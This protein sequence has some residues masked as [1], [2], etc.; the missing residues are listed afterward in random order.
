MRATVALKRQPLHPA[1]LNRLDINRPRPQTRKRPRPSLEGPPRNRDRSLDNSDPARA[2][3]HTQ[4][5]ACPAHCALW[6]SPAPAGASSWRALCLGTPTAHSPLP[7]FALSPLATAPYGSPGSMP[8]GWPAPSPQPMPRSPEPSSA[9][10]VRTDGWIPP[11]PPWP[12]IPGWIRAP[13]AAPSAVWPMPACSPGSAGWSG[14]AGPRARPP[15]PIA[16]CRRASHCRRRLLNIGGAVPGPSCPSQARRP[17]KAGT[18]SL[19]RWRNGRGI[20]CP[21][22]GK[23]FA[24]EGQTTILCLGRPSRVNH[25]RR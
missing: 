14:Q 18:G 7:R 16:S 6:R 5:L 11:M 20:V 22:I 1:R 15:M 17:S 25:G 23:Q 8:P 9:G 3:F 10:W 19:R 24:L 12:P 13:S 4:A 2:D 21:S